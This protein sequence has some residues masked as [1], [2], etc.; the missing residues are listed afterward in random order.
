MAPRSIPPLMLHHRISR[1][2]PPVPPTKSHTVPPVP[3][4]ASGR[5][6]KIF[7]EQR[8]R[9]GRCG[10]T[11]AFLPC[12]RQGHGSPPGVN[13]KAVLPP[14][15]SSA[16][17][18]YAALRCALSP[19]A[20]LAR[21]SG[22]LFAAFFSPGRSRPVFRRVLV[23]TAR[24]FNGCCPLFRQQYAHSSIAFI[25]AK[26]RRACR[27]STPAIAWGK[28]RPP[29][30]FFYTK[31]SS[32][33]NSPSSD[34]NR[35]LQYVSGRGFCFLP[36]WVSQSFALSQSTRA[37]GAPP[38][39]CPPAL[40]SRLA[41]VVWASASLSSEN[42]F[43]SPC[44]HWPLRPHH[45]PSPR[46][47]PTSTP[48]GQKAFVNSSNGHRLR[49]CSGW[50]LCVAVQQVISSQPPSSRIVNASSISA[51]LMPVER[52]TGAPMRVP[53]FQVRQVGNFP[54]GDLHHRQAP[55][56]T[57]KSRLGRSKPED[58]YLMRCRRSTPYSLGPQTQMQ[59]AYH[60]QLLSRRRSVPA[61][62]RPFGQN[63]SPPAP[64]RRS[65]FPQRRRPPFW[66][67]LPCVWPPL[68]CV[69]VHTASA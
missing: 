34:G 5:A 60:V 4:P 26:S 27:P 51:V 63:G 49:P 58:S 28:F 54:R 2:P 66:Q 33:K 69:V 18:P 16:V 17:W 65:V 67:R 57:K 53:L 55:A 10:L 29:R 56:P 6:G 43:Q 1:M 62:T 36:R 7:A 31:F 21:A 14:H 13:G 30:F 22:S 23:T 45:T 3:K 12:G 24:L 48:A 37:C 25:A 35:R 64:A 38:P 39:P 32:V 42:A 44:S 40:Y 41:F 50:V 15:I 47:G 19:R 8:Q 11:I 59:P 68:S 46:Y 52:S 9:V 20:G 61:G